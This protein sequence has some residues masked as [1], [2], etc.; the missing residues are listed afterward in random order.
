[1]SDVELKIRI[2]TPEDLDEIMRIALDACEEN[3]FL[4]PNPQRLLMDIWPALNRDK[5]LIGIIS[6]P[7]GP[8]EGVILLRVGN[9]WYSDVMTIEEK[10]V[11][12]KK[13]FRNAKGGRARKLCEFGKKVADELQMPLIIGV[14]SNHRTQGKIKMYERIFGQPSGAYFLYGV[15][16]GEWN[17]STGE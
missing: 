17:G 11:F 16:T 8:A 1:M 4:P 5:G 9:L 7:N 13:E 10:A 6:Q 3:A 15:K 12:V 14:L 2:G